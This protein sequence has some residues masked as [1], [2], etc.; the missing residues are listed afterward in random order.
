MTCAICHI[1][2][3]RRHCPGV[4]GDICA[5]CCGTEREVTVNCPFECEF[6]QEARK[7]EKPAVELDKLPN[8][9]I[10]VSETALEEHQDLA[11]VIAQA[12]FRSA[13]RIPGIVDF[14]VRQALE[15]L[16]RTWRTLGTGLYY[17]TLPEDGL[18]VH[19]YRDV[20]RALEELRRREHETGI[21]R[22]RESDVLVIFVFFQRLELDRNNG[23]IRGRA[24]LN[25]LWDFYG[26][27]PPLEAPS[28][29]LILP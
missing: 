9:D 10:R 15:A 25:L 18:A 14:T 8:E 20:Q 29:S 17:E 6:L 27:P 19:V 23:R 1:R 24:F 7:H 11:A 16:I 22:T 26:A 2:R 12:L 5:I 3:P 13:L 28:S 4:G 21:S